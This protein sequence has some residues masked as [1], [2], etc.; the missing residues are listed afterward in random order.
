MPAASHLGISH[1]NLL[2][3]TAVIA[4]A[5]CNAEQTVR[6]L[7]SQH[8]GAADAIR[9]NAAQAQLNDARFSC[10]TVPVTAPA[11]ITLAII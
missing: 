4:V 1:H 7:L 6:L 10:G 2:P 11:T 3:T 9:T 5:W 8:T